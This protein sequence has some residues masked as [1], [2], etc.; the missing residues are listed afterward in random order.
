MPNNTIVLKGN[1]GTYHDEGRVDSASIL[2]GYLIRRTATGTVEPH[3]TAGGGAGAGGTVILVAKED[4]LQG[5]TIDDA[6]AD[7]ELV[8]IHKAQKG[9]VLQ[10]VLQDGQNA[11]AGGPLTSNGDGTLKVAAGADEIM[12]RALE[13]LNL[14]AAGADEFIKVEVV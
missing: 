12:F 3:G 10:M 14:T 4:S 6:Y 9:D 13:S 5:R 8:L 7:D 2:P 1:L 11:T